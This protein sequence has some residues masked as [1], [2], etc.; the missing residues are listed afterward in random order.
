MT[1]R[2]NKMLKLFNLNTDHLNHTQMKLK[3]LL[4]SGY[5]KYH[6]INLKIKLHKNYFISTVAFLTVVIDISLKSRKTKKNASVSKII[7]LKE[8]KQF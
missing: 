6:H 8:G 5:L 1:S 7:V 4:K 3:F 2:M